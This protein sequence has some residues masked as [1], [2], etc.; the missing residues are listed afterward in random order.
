VGEKVS[1]KARV[2]GVE[3]RRIMFRVEADDRLGPVGGGTHERFVVD[4]SRF[5]G[6]LEER[7]SS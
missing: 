6:K 2:T 5:M 1:V 7:Y 4:L 3:G